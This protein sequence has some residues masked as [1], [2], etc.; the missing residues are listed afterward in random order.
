MHCDG[1]LGLPALRLKLAFKTAEAGLKRRRVTEDLNLLRAVT[2]SNHQSILFVGDIEPR[3]DVQRFIR[4]GIR[5][6]HRFPDDTIGARKQSLYTRSE[7]EAFEFHP[8]I[9]FGPRDLV[10]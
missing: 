9:F 1:T 4:S 3:L 2:R 8:R 10:L 5:P 7:V 6:D